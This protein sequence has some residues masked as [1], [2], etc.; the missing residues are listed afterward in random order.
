MEYCLTTAML[1]KQ[2]KSFKALDGL[3]MH[4]PKGAIYGL[5]GRNGAGKTTLIRLIAGIQ[6]PTSG[7][8]TLYGVKNTDRGIHK[9]RRHMGAVVETP[10]IYMDMSAEENLKIQ[11]R[12]LGLPNYEGIPELLQLAR[13]DGCGKKK[14]KAFF[15]WDAPEAWDCRCPL[16]LA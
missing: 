14:S 11:Y 15:A 16:R 3:T 12:V 10:S 9:A 13:L 7:G 5:V 1:C 2:Y 8:Y 4:V 6:E